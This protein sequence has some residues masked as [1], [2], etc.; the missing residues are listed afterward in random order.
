MSIS[1]SQKVDYLW[2][3]IGTGVAKTDLPS[4]KDY[5]NEQISS[6]L[7]IRADTIWTN[8]GN[9]P[10]VIPSNSTAEI[11][12]HRA[13]SPIA[14][15][16]D[17]T[18]T[19]YRTWLTNYTDW[20]P[21]EFG[22]TYQVKAYVA[23]IGD[24]DPVVNGVNIPATGTGNNDE[25]FFDYK[26]GILH[27]IGTNLPAA[28]D[29]VSN[30]RVYVT[31]ARYVGPLGTGLSGIGDDLDPTLQANLD[32][33]G[34]AIISPDNTD[35]VLSPGADGSI[36]LDSAS[37]VLPSGSTSE[38]PTI[39]TEGEIRFNNTL[40]QVEYY[41]GTDWVNL[42]EDTAAIETETIIGDGSTTQY[43]L[44]R[45]TTA[46]GII[47]SINGTLQR[48]NASYTVS[49]DVITFAEAPQ[50]TDIVDIRHISLTVNVDNVVIQ[51]HTRL[52]TLSLLNPSIGQ[53][54]LVSDGDPITGG[55]CVAVF[56]G[57]Q[58][59]TLSFSG[60]LANGPS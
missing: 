29:G 51:K 54:V 60:D 46:A 19:H 27:F 31:G 17:T 58:W 8:S 1:D 18:S 15:L 12:L 48:P 9:I 10:P 6:P 21:P 30:V 37:L 43:T 50:T 59:K 23:P 53:T 24:I 2:K 3:K 52:E 13:N 11:Q 40:Q 32:L 42:G 41:N 55:S 49:G 4:K 25:W 28:I 34:Y 44:L 57:S 33:N 39:P 20:I 45:A 26:S 14:C 36:V 7:L 35:I 5:F 56:D 22:P 38:R 47:V 16:E